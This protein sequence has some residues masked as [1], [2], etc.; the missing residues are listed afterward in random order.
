MGFIDQIGSAL[1]SGVSSS[2]GGLPGA[3]LNFGLNTLM[4]NQ[5]VGKSKEL[6]KYQWDNFLSP[7]AQVE[8]MAAAGLNPA[9]TL[10][11]HGSFAS[12]QSVMPSSNAPIQV[13]GVSDMLGS[14]TQLKK[15]DKDNEL[16][17]VEIYKTLAEKGLI[18][19]QRHGMAIANTIAM[20]YGDKEAA[21]RIANLGAQ[22]SLFASQEKLSEAEKTFT[23][24]KGETE[25]V[26]KELVS[27]N[28]LKAALEVKNYQRYIDS[29]INS[30]QKQATLFEKQGNLAD[31]NAEAQKILNDIHGSEE[32]RQALID[33]LQQRA[34]T[35]KSQ[36]KL[37]D[38][39]REYLSQLARLAETNADWATWN[40]I[41]NSTSVG[42]NLVF[43]GIDRFTK[44]GMLKNASKADVE[45][46]TQVRFDKDG[47]YLG[48][49]ETNRTRSKQ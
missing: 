42:A 10:G 23:E 11:G 43:D 24:L 17:D 35:L 29:V 36:N 26:Y 28:K 31:V 15:V 18:D 12:P 22:S 2:I 39:S 13:D 19:E 27:K 5:Q 7:K 38:A 6:M 34:R 44:L 3:A 41:L 21:A 46:S 48:H 20:E 4:Q 37:N 32:G 49:T 45:S 14:L 40:Q 33:E 9:V 30:N 47:N 25:K 8:S 1:A 16:V